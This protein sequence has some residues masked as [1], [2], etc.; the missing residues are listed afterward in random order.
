MLSSAGLFAS[1]LLFFAF[2]SSSG[3]AGAVVSLLPGFASAEA[4]VAEEEEELED[5]VLVPGA[6]V[7][8]SLAAAVGAAVLLLPSDFFVSDIALVTLLGVPLRFVHTPFA[9]NVYSFPSIFIDLLVTIFPS[10]SK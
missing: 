10:A 8:A 6:T 5:S 1:S 7:G 2:A 9:S 4:W 3:E